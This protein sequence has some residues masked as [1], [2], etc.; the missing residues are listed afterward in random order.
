MLCNFVFL[1]GLGKIVA[2]IFCLFEGVKT[3]GTIGCNLEPK[4]N[5]FKEQEGPMFNG[6]VL[7]S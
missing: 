5:S 2:L 1:F 4:G 7:E 6:I 3:K